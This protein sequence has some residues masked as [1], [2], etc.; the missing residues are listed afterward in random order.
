MNRFFPSFLFALFALCASAQQTFQFQAR[1]THDFLNT[2]GVNTAIYRRGENLPKTIEC[3][4]YIG[5]RWI[6]TDEAMNTPRQQ[7]IIRNLHKATGVKIS[8][9]LG[10]GGSDIK[11]LVEGSR[12]VAEMGALLAI[13]GNNEPNNWGVTYQGEQGGKSHSWAPVARLHR[14]LYK[15]VKSDPVL[16]SYPVWATTETGAQTDNVGLQFLTVP[17]DHPHVKKEFRG[18]TFADVLNCHNYFV[19][20][21]W[22]PLKDNQTWLA[23][24]PTEEGRGDNLHGNYSRTWSRQFTGYAS[25]ELQTLPRV[26]TETGTTIGGLVTEEM[27]G[28]LYLSC[29]LSQYAQGWSHTA[30]Y[31]LRDRS[32]EGGN[33]TFGFYTPD[34]RPRRA[35][36]Y[37][38]NLTTILADP[39]EPAELGTLTYDITPGLPKTVHQLLFQHSDGAFL[40]VIWGELYD[41][42]K[43]VLTVCLDHKPRRVRVY[44]PTQSSEPISDFYGISTIPLCVTTQPYILKIE[45][46]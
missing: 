25:D 26:T 28:R 17:E 18:A 1:S 15:A 22:K 44:D 14:D 43:E 21:S 33:Q 2:I 6:R 20:P 8:T 11:A 34:Y 42:G 10:S 27:Q 36:H 32:D 23:A 37:L 35:A 4:K 9:S 24:C 30:M 40:L 41:G 31:L 12:K 38:H 5:A 19:H 29:Y 7:E 3:M 16:K 39:N 45:S 46:E 13:E